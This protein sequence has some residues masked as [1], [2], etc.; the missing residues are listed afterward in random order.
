MTTDTRKIPIAK[1]ALSAVPKAEIAKVFS[2]AGEISM[3]YV[4]MAEIADGIAFEIPATSSV[5]PIEMNTPATPA[6]PEIR[7][8]LKSRSIFIR[9]LKHVIGTSVWKTDSVH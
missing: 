3:T 7:P 8:A 9:Q 1:T 6:Q 5:A 2:H 4:P